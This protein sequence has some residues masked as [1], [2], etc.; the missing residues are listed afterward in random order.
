MPDTP[1]A[2]AGTTETGTTQQTPPAG[3]APAPELTGA[4]KPGAE[5]AG[6]GTPA[7]GEKPSETPKPGETPVTEVVPEKYELKLADGSTLPPTLVEKTAAT[8]RSLGLSNAKAQALLDATA[9]EV[10]A[11]AEAV[12]ASYK[13]GGTEYTK[14]EQAWAAQALADTEIGGSKEKL[15]ENVAQA[16][17]VIAT[18]FPESIYKFLNDTGFGSH[19]DVI[20]GFAKLGRAMS[21]G[22]IVEGAQLGTH[23]KEEKTAAE[24]IY[25]GT[26]NTNKG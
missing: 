21:E 9:A 16:A 24:K 8:A 1:A 6:Q 11:H 23:T 19:P 2:G 26:S 10:T 7:G 22:K 20:R 15:D 25:G 4:N 17:K 13:P 3:G 5:T 18:F 12:L 14:Q